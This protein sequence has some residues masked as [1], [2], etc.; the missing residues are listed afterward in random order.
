MFASTLCRW[1]FEVEIGLPADGIPF[2]DWNKMKAAETFFEPAGNGDML[3]MADDAR[4][5]NSIW[6]AVVCSDGE[7]AMKDAIRRP[8]YTGVVLAFLL[9]F[10]LTILSG[11]AHAQQAKPTGFPDAPGRDLLLG[12]CFQ[13]HGDGIW[14]DHRQDQRG[15][16]GV[17]Y[18]MVGR[19]ALWTEQEIGTMAGYLATVRGTSTDKTQR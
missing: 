2:A 10:P 16:E 15:W 1:N 18:R 19:G 5:R 4:C 9:V 12:R 7:D 14:R 6:P 17:L 13:C 11:V 8:G 3:V